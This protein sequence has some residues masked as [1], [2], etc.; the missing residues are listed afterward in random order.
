MTE[1]TEMRLAR[2]LSTIAATLFWHLKNPEA[3]L[4]LE[5]ASA[6]DE[7]REMLA[8]MSERHER[9][10]VYAASKEDPYPSRPYSEIRKELMEEGLLDGK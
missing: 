9:L 3:R 7:L 5:V 8:D 1:T 6:R 2:I 10:L 4:E